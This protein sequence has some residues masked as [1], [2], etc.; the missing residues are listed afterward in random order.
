[1]HCL[2]INAKGLGQLEA[3]LHAEEGVAFQMDNLMFWDSLGRGCD[4]AIQGVSEKTESS[5]F[6]ITLL[7]SG[8]ILLRDWVGMYLAPRQSGHP[9]TYPILPV[10]HSEN[11][12]L[13]YEVFHRDNMVAFRAHNGL[14]LSRVFRSFHTI[15]AAKRFADDS[16]YFRPVIG[17]L[18]SPT[19]QIVRVIPGN[20]SRVKCYRCVLKKETYINR[21]EAPEN[22]T[23]T[24]T[25][26]T[27]HADRV[28]WK[29][30][31]G[32]G[33]ASSLQFNIMDMTA[34]VKYSQDNERVVT[35]MRNISETC[36][37]QVV[38]PPRM[39]ATARLVFSKDNATAVSFVAM[40]TKTKSD[41]D[42]VILY[43][44]GAWSGLVYFNVRLEVKIEEP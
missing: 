13:Q 35:V 37:E 9:N 30:L 41:G 44:P 6:Q 42:V 14:F 19:L 27:Q 12:A 5:K 20:L 23:F 38:V 18:L 43:E 29:R 21:S 11:A 16:C 32:L 22:H 25:W 33:M 34:T 3:F 7:P 8:K 36:T 15:E 17:D 24:M 31:W 4:W 40:I 39:K 1:M 2:Q 26:E 28:F 10:L